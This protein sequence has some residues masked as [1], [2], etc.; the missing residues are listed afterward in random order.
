MTAIKQLLGLDKPPARDTRR[1]VKEVLDEAC[2]H[3]KA[4]VEECR[5]LRMERTG[6]IVPE[7]SVLGPWPK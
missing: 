1:R 2:R 7:P 6:E 4:A 3:E 5:R